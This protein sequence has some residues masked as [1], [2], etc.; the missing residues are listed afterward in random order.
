[1]AAGPLLVN[2]KQQ[3]IWLDEHPNCL[4]LDILGMFISDPGLRR[5]AS[6]FTKFSRPL[7]DVGCATAC[8][9]GTGGTTGTAT[10]TAWGCAARG[11]MG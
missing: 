9:A 1:V 5:S 11:P 7:G 6:W 8:V 2:I 3:K 10:C 4:I